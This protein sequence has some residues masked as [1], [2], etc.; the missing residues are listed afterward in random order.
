MSFSLV[1]FARDVTERDVKQKSVW[2]EE[3]DI[4][5]K[6]GG[7][8]N[9]VVTVTGK[10]GKQQLAG[11]ANIFIDPASD[12]PVVS[13]T[14]PNTNIDVTGNLNIV[15]T[16]VDDD[17]VGYVE[18]ILDGNTERPV[19]A[20]GKEFWSYYLDTSNMKEGL[21]TIEARGVDI[22]GLSGKPLFLQWSF[23][24]H[25]PVSE[26]TNQSIGA[27]LSKVVKLEGTV[28]DG[29]GIKSL[30]YSLDGGQRFKEI[31]LNRKKEGVS[32][33]L[34]IDTR[35]LADG[36]TVIWFK[37]VDM[38]RS[39]G[40]YTYMFFVD[41]TAPEVSI[42]YPAEG[43]EPNGVFSV[44]GFVR[45]A[46]SVGEVLWTAD[47][48]SGSFDLTPGNPYWVKELDTTANR[49][50][51]IR[52]TVTARDLAGNTT[53]VQKNIKLNQNADKPVLVLQSP[54]ADTVARDRG[55][56]VLRGIA[57]DDDAVESVIYSFDAGPEQT[58]QTRGVFCAI[59][60]ENERLSA[61][62]HTVT[63]RAVDKYG[64][65]GNPVTVTFNA[66]GPAGSFSD[67][68]IRVS[69]REPEP[70]HYGMQLDPSLKPVYETSVS[71]DCGIAYVSWTLKPES[72]AV[73]TGERKNSS[74]SPKIDL[75]IPLS[76][77]PAG[78]LS[79]EISASDKYGRTLTQNTVLGIMNYSR[80]G[81]A[82]EVS[83]PA[84][85][86]APPSSDTAI[87]ILV[88]T[89]PENLSYTGSSVN[90]RG[91]ADDEGGIERVDYSYD[92]GISWT[93]CNIERTKGTD[94]GAVFSATI[95]LLSEDGLV[96]INIRAADKTGNE[97]FAFLALYKDTAPP[98]VEMV[99]PLSSDTVNG[100][101]TLAF[102]VSDNDHLAKAE[103]IPPSGDSASTS[104]AA[105]AGTS[106]ARTGITPANTAAASSTAS[107]AAV[108]KDIP[109]SSLVNVM[110]GTDSY[111][112]SSGMN[113]VFTDA[114]GNEA[115]VR[116]VPFTI[117]AASDMPRVEMHMPPENA[118]ETYDFTVSGVIYDDDG[119]SN[120]YYKID[121]GQ[122]I[123][124]TNNSSNFNFTVPI[125]ALSDNEHVL[126][127][128]AVDR[129]GVKGEETTRK[130]RVSLNEPEGEVINPSFDKTV[131]RDVLI[132]GT[133]HDKN[134]IEKVMVSLDNGN[135]YHDAAGKEK[136]SFRFDSRIISDGS[137]V[138]FYK[139]Y[140]SYGIQ[141]LYS[142]LINI[143][144]TAPEISLVSPV[145]GTRTSGTVFFSGYTIDNIKLTELNIA[146]H[147][148]D[149]AFPSAAAGKFSNIQ[150]EPFM[151][152]SKP[153]DVSAL[154]DGFYNF[155][156]IGKDAAGNET[157]VTRN[158]HVDKAFPSAAIGILYPLTGSYVNGRFNIAA[159][160]ETQETVES[161]VLIMDGIVLE[162]SEITDAGYCQFE[163]G[164][165]KVS[166]GIHT[167]KIQ[168]SLADGKIAVSA[169]QE[170]NYSPYGPWIMLEKFV[171]GDFAIGRPYV[172]GK[173][174]YFVSDEEKAYVNS[175]EAF[176]EE[177]N[178][179]KEKSVEYIELSLDN[180]KT[181]KNISKKES[182]KYRI[183]TD[184]L[185][186]GYHFMLV[187]AV[188]KDG[189]TAVLNTMVQIDKSMPSVLLISPTEGGRYNQKI[190]FDGLADGKRGL[191][192]V[193]LALRDGDKMM[194]GIPGFIQGLYFDIH[195]WGATLFDVGVGV[196]FFDDNV[197]LQFQYG[198]LT[199]SQRNMIKG[200]PFR[201]GGN[202]IGT[203]ILANVASMPFHYFFG[204]D[205][206]WLSANVALGANFSRFDNTN[207][208][209]AQI[210]SA[211]LAQLE[212][213][214]MTFEQ[215]KKF[216]TMSFYTEFQLWFIPTDISEADGVK[217]IV[218]QV[219]VGIRLN[220]F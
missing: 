26:I 54:S 114:A 119:P 133:A 73:I 110:V 151:L 16:C 19:R 147:S 38:W 57:T 132:E 70:V 42:V 136:W 187:R 207:S 171:L 134:G 217:N 112:I 20:E 101:T 46:V 14:N 84:E 185:T 141:G 76:A 162:K 213:P 65:S 61:G 13:I 137:H 59:L 174:G 74:S 22:N 93:P 50:S 198:Q 35:K 120:C 163:L 48:Q 144:N 47:N 115:F 29:N 218:P 11:P 181:F 124:L 176:P 77:V 193:K 197:K 212:F 105:N 220:V 178:A 68:R 157:R 195:F 154:D 135:T 96:P 7:K 215:L 161:L 1:V 152:I 30:F 89:A 63:V 186:E 113:F 104:A 31:K 175:K 219:G 177:K 126:T 40:I 168:A 142:S 125:S 28:S 192:E 99:L 118:V 159:K 179:F 25:G 53:T 145:D 214:R 108:R 78:S 173:A 143:D 140:D 8:Y 206:T 208:G 100:A 131:S 72:G 90:I 117:D 39:E 170:L 51:S 155:E 199:Q 111:P 4:S 191:K 149:K 196:S 21:H 27:L 45:D 37:S 202:V 6:K 216:R 156:I 41:N 82:S 9:F 166:E 189:S 164:P 121:D 52:F 44:A 169:E 2:H 83:V 203:K 67:A 17:G 205:F 183:E 75:S 10:N 128:Y 43:D 71:A 180:G 60:D 49:S 194:Y 200:S 55:S 103:Y 80:E 139:I 201:Y 209:K 146:V 94:A 158:V 85:P 81:G 153:V 130:F 33:L 3:F 116:S 150:L 66:E 204:P 127:V 5:D 69:G 88:V 123:E 92:G 24:P 62:K 36:P 15:G 184:Y 79:V 87:P 107:G 91:T 172:T 102:K 148:L 34:E 23:N 106:A 138:V 95:N 167:Y 98:V 12:L 129:N 64:V 190:S 160:I 58:I 32:F 97:A 182:W 109:L 210:L 165:E 86:I 188:M 56:V 122:W 18:L 211:I